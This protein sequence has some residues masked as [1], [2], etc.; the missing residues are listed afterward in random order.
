MESQPEAKPIPWE[1]SFR[2][3]AF[4]IGLVAVALIA[5][6]GLKARAESKATT[7]A[8]LDPA[9][10]LS[11]PALWA[12]QVDKETLLSIRDLQSGGTFKV[13]FSVAV[14]DLEPEGIEP[15][16]SLVKEITEERGQELTA[17][18]ILKTA[19]TTLDDLEA[20]EIS[21]AYVDDSAGGVLRT[22]LPVVVQGV[23][24]LVVRGTNLYVFTFAAPATS[25]S[26]QTGTLDAIL[27]SVRFKPEN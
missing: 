16:Q 4:V 21:Y 10:S 24:I 5:G 22:S 20:A 7:Y 8:E 26:Q 27:R 18:R 6:W 12:T 19:D 2:Y 23:D 11:Y 17:Y 3:D 14:R 9:L 13:S 25:F 15:V 1:I